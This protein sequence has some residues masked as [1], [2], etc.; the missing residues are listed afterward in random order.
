MSPC[1]IF[2]NLLTAHAHCAALLFSK[3]TATLDDNHRREIEGKDPSNLSVL[4][5]E[6]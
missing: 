6:M 4:Y 5:S 2:E 3:I 1:A